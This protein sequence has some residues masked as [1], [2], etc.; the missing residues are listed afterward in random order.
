MSF[1]PWRVGVRGIH[2]PPALL[3][4]SSETAR[5][6]AGTLRA[7]RQQ[8][9]RGKRGW[10]AW[11]AYCA[12][13]W[14]TDRLPRPVARTAEVRHDMVD[15]SLPVQS[16]P[17][18]RSRGDRS[19][20]CGQ[21]ALALRSF[22]GGV[23]RTTPIMV[24][25]TAGRGCRGTAPCE[26][27]P[28]DHRPNAKTFSRA[29]MPGLPQVSCCRRPSFLPIGADRLAELRIHANACAMRRF[30]QDIA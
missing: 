23:L 6:V 8:V 28:V 13:A 27:D 17:P 30:G 16:G 2:G 24:V 14:W 15:A 22:N 1:P 10:E 18:G 29:P 3:R 11:R 21:V 7:S 12:A 26:S 20:E 9:A 25:A 4:L 5:Y 19:G